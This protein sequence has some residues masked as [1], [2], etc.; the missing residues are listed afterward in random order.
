[1]DMLYL[2][3]AAFLVLT[4]AIGLL[5]VALGPTAPDR[6]LAAQLLG[7]AGVAALLLLA[8]VHDEAALRDAALIYA[9]LSG[10]AT[11]AFVRRVRLSRSQGPN[12]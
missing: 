6:M 4:I 9:L 3:F 5:R 12:R 7:T 11:V 1:M 10:I 2:M 8:E